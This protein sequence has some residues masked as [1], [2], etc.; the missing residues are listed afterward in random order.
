MGGGGKEGLV[1]E[2]DLVQYEHGRPEWAL[3]SE[4]ASAGNTKKTTKVPKRTL[5]VR[6]E[7][8]ESGEVLSQGLRRYEGRGALLTPAIHRSGCQLGSPR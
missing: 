7:R 5:D 6:F 4:E 1:G 8:V 2:S 3:L